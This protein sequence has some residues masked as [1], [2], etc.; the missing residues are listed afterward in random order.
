MVPW[1]L[2]LLVADIILS[3]LLPI[4]AFL[5]DLCYDISSA[6]AESVWAGIQRIFTVSN[7]AQ[8]VVSGVDKLPKG[9][10]AI[11]IANHVEWTDFYMIQELAQ[12]AGMLN[13]C[14]WFAKQQLKWVPFLG[15]GLWAMGMPL[16][17]RNWTEDQKEMDRVFSGVVQK[18]WPI[19]LIA[20][21]EGSRY[22]NWR[23]DEAEAWCRSHDKRLGKHVLY[24]RTKGFLACVHNLRKAP[25]VKAVYDVT[26]AYAKH[27]KVFQQPPLFQETVTIPDL[28]KEWRFFVHVDRYTL[29]DL[30][31]TDEKLARWL[32]DRWVEKGERLELLRQQLV[33]GLPWSDLGT[34]NYS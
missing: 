26:I 34:L 1:L 6:I 9:E 15:W 23:R 19:W 21:S 12:R 22:T 11:V 33:K 3:A 29:S 20:Y 28:D 30:P 8:I 14:R 10:S 24:P 17:S 2:H 31:S 4:S 13:R 16:I 27:E 32:E 7:H 18:H 25:H 5:P